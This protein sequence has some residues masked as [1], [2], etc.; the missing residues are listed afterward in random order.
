MKLSSARKEK[1]MRE[2]Q[3]FR[4]RT[5]GNNKKRRSSQ[6]SSGLTSVVSTCIVCYDFIVFCFLAPKQGHESCRLLNL[7]NYF[8]KYCNNKYLKIQMVKR[9]VVLICSIIV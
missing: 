5:T 4:R 8:Y 1:R 3:G 7:L 2:K 6:G 9:D